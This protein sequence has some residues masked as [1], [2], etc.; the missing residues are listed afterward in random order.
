M[1]LIF[2]VL[3][4]SDVPVTGVFFVVFDEVSVVG[5]VG[6]IPGIVCESIPV[7]F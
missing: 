6:V 7:V 1:S 4:I 3:W 2:R 5:P